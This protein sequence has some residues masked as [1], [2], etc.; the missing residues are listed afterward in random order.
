MSRKKQIKRIFSVFLAT[1]LL[2][3]AI[4][5]SLAVQNLLDEET[6]PKIIREV[7]ELREESVKHFLCE[8]GSYIAATYSAP[9]HYKENGE[10]K[11][12]D[13]SLSLDRTTLS[14]SGKPTYTTKAGGLSVSI[15][16][17]FSDG[18]K[19]TARNKGY[20]IGF[21]VNA[22]QN[23]VSVKASASVVDVGTLSSNI[24]AVKLD[25]VKSI[26]NV[27][28]ASTLDSS[29]T[30]AYNAEIMTVDNQSSAVT[31]EKIMPDTDFEYIVTSN[32]I[33]ENIVVYEPKS[34]Y[35]YSF[36]MDF[37]GLT[38]II[39]PDN[40]ISLVEP[41]NPDETIFFI[42]APYMYDSNGEESI[43]IEMSLV[44]NGDEYVMTLVA[45][46]D[47]INDESRAFPVVIDPTICFWGSGINDVFVVDG[48]YAGSTRIKDK[49]RVGRDLIN[50]TR[51]YLKPELPV[52]IPLGSKITSATLKFY[53]DSYYQAPSG[54]DIR[55]L[56][57]DC[58]NVAT[59]ELDEIS[60]NNQPFNNSDN[61]YQSTN[62]A[63][64]LSGTPASSTTLIYSFNIKE[65]VQRWVNGG[66]NNGIL[67][68]SSDESTKTQVDLFSSR[69]SNSSYQPNIFIE[70][71]VP[72]TNRTAWTTG[73]EADYC[74]I[75]VTATLDWTAT[76]NRSWLTVTNV[77][78]SAFRIAVS[79]NTGFQE[80]TGQIT[81]TMGDTVISTIEVVQYGTEPT[82]LIDKQSW[83]VYGQSD[84]TEVTVTSNDNWNIIIDD[85][86]IT[87][88]VS[89][90]EDNAVVTFEV[91]ENTGTKRETTVTFANESSGIEKTFSI[92]QL[93][94]ASSY[95]C[96]FDSNGNITS[97]GSS[98]Y[99]HNLATWSMALSYAAYN[100]I[101]YQALPFI[102]SGFM[103]EPYND[104]TKTAEA[105][106]E[107]LGFDATS[108]NYDGGYL[109]YAAHTI[110]HKKITINNNTTGDDS[111]DI[112]VTNAF[113]DNT[114]SLSSYS[115]PVLETDNRSTLGFFADSVGMDP[116]IVETTLE[117][118]SKSRT[119]IVISV[120]GSVTPLDWAMDLANQINYDNFNFETGCQEV[121]ASLNSYLSSNDEIEDNPIILVTGHSLGA[122]IANLVAHEL[123]NGI[124]S[125]DVYA[126]TFASPNTVNSANNNPIEYT[127]IFNILNN[128]D[129]VPHFPF[130]V[131]GNVWTRHGQD[132]HITMPLNIDWIVGVDYALLGIAGHGMPNYYEW[133][134]NLP[135]ELGKAAENISI[136]DLL[137]LSEDYAVGLAAKVLKAKCPVSVTLYDNNGNIVAYESQQSGTVYPEIT[138]VGIVSWIT[139]NNEK[140]FL[141]PYGC[142]ALEVCI[143]AYDYGTM[144]LTVEQ[145]GIGEPLSTITYNDVSLYS[146][147]EFLVEVSEETLPEDTQLFVTENGEIVGEIT[148]TNPF[149]KGVTANPTEAVYGETVTFTLVT[150]N[151]VTAMMLHNTNADDHVNLVPGEGTFNV[152]ASGENELTW[153]V[154]NNSE[155]MNPGENVYDLSVQSDGVWYFYEN[156]I[157]LN[158]TV[159]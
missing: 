5:L 13:N 159:S 42:E 119:L 14:E 148:D 19:I 65:A 66:V 41:N 100:P 141:I 52:N 109:G 122:A 61:G 17:S 72:R 114:N 156:V 127:N 81:V 95:F 50:V 144:N 58:C 155:V 35:T 39:N 60:W 150:D 63:V 152:E 10:W 143:E 7:T 38:P 27:S 106:L 12:I 123:N 101:E 105:E 76:S 131:P 89:E 118:D 80:R 78:D 20:E 79:D 16:Q 46:A 154:T 111:N 142:E 28:T 1:V 36:D 84:T 43:D 92:T 137:E 157:A 22:N 26:N 53:K 85:D 151:T 124:S 34:E 11:E 48:L 56:A 146:G 15:P 51:T 115:I 149:F 139:E 25:T 77:Y 6:P 3:S 94:I 138:D 57:Y 117:S 82:L 64:Y 70:Y 9:V 133:L 87:A 91:T 104:E 30:E 2:I 68:A 112:N 108:Y 126:Y 8:D 49:V 102:P 158:V 107:S 147:K 136:D 32:S 21:G 93:D 88:S 62:G 59:W 90:G 44:A 47:W 121:I 45:S 134:N 96:E 113:N 74:T 103:Q 37:D 55:I 18:Q 67:L 24:E 23:D 135:E 128:N 116:G 110:G 31:Y 125:P 4:P 83:N 69:Y 145:P 73:K 97:K 153:T 120:R 40:S 98:Q 33:K 132:F 129:F 130:D 29:D 99:N 75:A 54:E 71:E 140:M 86:W